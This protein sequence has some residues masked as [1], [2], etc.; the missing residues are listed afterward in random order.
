[1][2]SIWFLLHDTRTYRYVL[3]VWST[4]VSPHWSTKFKIVASRLVVKAMF[5]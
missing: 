3:V 5:S 2:S 4:R 1:M